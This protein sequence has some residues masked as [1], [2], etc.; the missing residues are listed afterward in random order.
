MFYK[1]SVSPNAHHSRCKDC[2]KKEAIVSRKNS[3]NKRDIVLRSKYGITLDQFVQM[4]KDQNGQCKICS[5]SFNFE[6]YGQPGSF[7][8]DHDHNTGAVRGLLCAHCNRG[9][10]QFKENLQFIKNAVIYLEEHNAQ[11]ETCSN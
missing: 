10:G 7:C 1:H 3:P 2:C 4:F 8:V 5:T 9:I 6:E 11:K